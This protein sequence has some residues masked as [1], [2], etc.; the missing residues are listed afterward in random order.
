MIWQNYFDLRHVR[1]QNEDLQTTVDRLRLEQAALLE[2]A[3]QGQRLQAI[4]NFQEKY[5][6]K[7]LVRPNHRH[8]RQRPIARLLSSTRVRPT[9]STAIWR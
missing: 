6:Y 7:T 2:D 1:Q 3:R 5:I 9:D 4:L 8:Q